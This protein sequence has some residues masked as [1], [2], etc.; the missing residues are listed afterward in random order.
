MGHKGNFGLRM[1]R[2]DAQGKIGTGGRGATGEAFCLCRTVEHYGSDS[3]AISSNS[4]AL[5]AGA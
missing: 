5:K 1:F 4:D 2:I 3:A